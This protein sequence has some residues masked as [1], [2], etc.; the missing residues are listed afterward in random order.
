MQFFPIP[1]LLRASLRMTDS[2]VHAPG[3]HPTVDNPAFFHQRVDDPSVLPS[4]C[5]HLW[6]RLASLG[7]L[8]LQVEKKVHVLGV[9]GDG[10]VS[11]NPEDGRGGLKFDFDKYPVVLSGEGSCVMFEWSQP[12][13]VMVTKVLEHCRVEYA[14]LFPISSSSSSS[15]TSSSSSSCSEGWSLPSLQLCFRVTDV[16]MFIYALTPGKV[17]SCIHMHLALSL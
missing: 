10:G 5:Q 2:Y 11:A 7:R 13:V 8:T 15:S 12:T 3:Y 16:N 4:L 1:F 9:L 6:G 17:S 14:D